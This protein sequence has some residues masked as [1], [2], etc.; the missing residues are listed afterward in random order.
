MSY[1]DGQQSLR[2]VNQ[3]SEGC[4]SWVFPGDEPVHP[5]DLRKHLKYLHRCIEEL[6]QRINQLD[7]AIE[8]LR[9]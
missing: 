1:E 5:D 9:K 7:D 8:S 6:Y 4:L 3:R 2:K